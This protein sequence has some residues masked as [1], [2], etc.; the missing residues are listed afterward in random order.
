M[1]MEIF[2]IAGVSLILCCMTLLL[3][4]ENGAFSFLLLLGGV[5]TLACMIFPLLDPVLEWIKELSGSLAGGALGYLFKALGIAFIT[6]LAQ[7]LCKDV[8]AGA[9]AA[10]VELGGR[11]LILMAVFPML[12]G[13][14]H[15]VEGL[16]G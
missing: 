10:M 14:L 13:V 5:L 3:K 11:A 15:Q 1:S 9:L 7:E 8:G 6:Q 4:K 16:L 2:Q 12:Q